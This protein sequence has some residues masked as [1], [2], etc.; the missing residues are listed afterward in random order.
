MTEQKTP[1]LQTSSQTVGPFFHYGLIFGEEH[2]LVNE[3][4]LG[5]RIIIT[6]T[7]FDG[8]GEPIPDALVE[9]WQAD[10][11][12]Y[13]D[14]PEDPNHDKADKHFKY[15]GRSDTVK[16]GVYSFKTVKPAVATCNNDTQE[17]PYVCVRVFSRGMLIHA[18]TRMYFP[19][20]KNNETDVLL[21][22]I[23]ANKKQTLIA[24]LVENNDLPTYHFDIHLQGAEETVFLD[25]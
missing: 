6:G 15:F 7:V 14:H 12:G 23:D 8:D 9:I 20:E 2:I 24:R 3:H 11:N 5:Q 22:S 1:L 4:T 19:N 10:V 21:N 16:N 25:L 18:V 17:A 13:F